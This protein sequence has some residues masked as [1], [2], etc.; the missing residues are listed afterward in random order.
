MRNIL[1]MVL[2]LGLLLVI[3]PTTAKA[4]DIVEN[5]VFNDTATCVSSACAAFGFSSGPLTGSYQFDVTTQMIVGPWS[6]SSP[7]RMLSSTDVG[8]NA[9]VSTLG[10]PGDT[11]DSFGISTASFG[12]FFTL[13]FP[14][15]GPG[16]QQIGPVDSASNGCTPEAGGGACDPG[17]YAVTGATTLAPEPSS[18]LL[19][20]TGLLGLMR[21]R[22]KRLA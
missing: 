9:T 21:P 4:N 6:F 13:Y 3:G 22:R 14:G 12:E 2:I 18:L 15:A 5:L 20:G 19:L 8:A 1:A 10:V 7:L 11:G 17:V 16:A